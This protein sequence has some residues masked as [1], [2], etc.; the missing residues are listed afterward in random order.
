MGGGGGG[1]C[2]PPPP[3]DRRLWLQ[4]ENHVGDPAKHGEKQSQKTEERLI[5]PTLNQLTGK[6]GDQGN[7]LSNPTEWENMDF[8]Q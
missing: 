4:G 7:E 6:Y 2:P 5:L 8:K 3:Q 1:D